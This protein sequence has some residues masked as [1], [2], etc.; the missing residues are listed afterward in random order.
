M[1]WSCGDLGAAEYK[2]AA[3][4]LLGFRQLPKVP[5]PLN[6]ST[7]T[8]EKLCRLYILAVA[9]GLDI[10]LRPEDQT[11]LVNH[12]P[13]RHKDRKHF[14]LQVKKCIRAVRLPKN[15]FDDAAFRAKIQKIYDPEW[16]PM[17]TS[18][19]QY[20]T[21]QEWNFPFGPPSKILFPLFSHA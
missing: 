8:I 17:P 7:K 18:T 4:A 5:E 9:R 12:Y 21:S 1:R 6:A 20:L 3:N 15:R 16:A 13:K 14:E 10:E 19:V 11:W 2:G